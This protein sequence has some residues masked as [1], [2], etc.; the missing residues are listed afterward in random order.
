MSRLKTRRNTRQREAIV[1]V[2][3]HSRSHPTASDVYG[4]VKERLPKISLGTV[5]RN[6]D[7]LTDIGRVR[8]LETSGTEARFDGN[9]DAHEHVR[10][11]TCGKVDD[12]FLPEEPFRENDVDSA[13]GYRIIGRRLEFV[14][15]CPSCQRK[16]EVEEKE[17]KEQTTR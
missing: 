9:L 17:T 8:K 6:L 11:V 16:T 15:V 3:R 10:C 12:V 7:F 1:D 13:S 5:Y 4:A 2:L 14:G